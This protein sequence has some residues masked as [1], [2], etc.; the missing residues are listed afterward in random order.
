MRPHSTPSYRLTYDDAVEI[1]LLYWDGHFQN[2]IAAR[3]D[4]NPARVSNVIKERTFIG[5]KADAM[6]RRAA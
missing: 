1:W 3:F 6:K 5:S 2:R 4:T